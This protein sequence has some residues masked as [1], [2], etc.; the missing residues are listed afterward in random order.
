[1]ENNE[2]KIPAYMK[3]I[4]FFFIAALAAP[5][6]MLLVFLNWS[7]ITPQMRSNHLIFSILMTLLYVSKILPD[8]T[9]KLLLTALALT[10]ILFVTYIVI[11]GK[12]K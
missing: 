6:A 11:G 10:L 9:L 7:K 2:R 5:V 12:R 3:N 4:P 8:G 1:M